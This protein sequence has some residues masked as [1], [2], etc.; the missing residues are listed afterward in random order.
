MAFLSAPSFGF[1]VVACFT[2]S[3]IIS[4]A[5]SARSRQSI[6][7]NDSTSTQWL[8]ALNS[9]LAGQSPSTAKC[10]WAIVLRHDAIANSNSTRCRFSLRMHRGPSTTLLIAHPMTFFRAMPRG[11]SHRQWPPSPRG[12]FSSNPAC[13]TRSTY[14]SSTY[15]ALSVSGSGQSFGRTRHAGLV[16]HGHSPGERNPA[17]TGQPCAFQHARPQHC[18]PAIR[19]YC[20]CRAWAL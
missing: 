20:T 3:T 11:S 16:R 4:A 18:C 2:R 9:Q 6:L 10:D 5:F 17:W 13:I 14:F 15:L 7:E 1:R 12:C 19:Q 8:R